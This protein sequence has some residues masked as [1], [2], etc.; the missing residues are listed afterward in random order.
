[1]KT[2]IIIHVLP[3]EI[4]RF[5]HQMFELHKNSKYLEKNDEV[6]IDATLNVNDLLVDWS[7]SKI[8][9]QY[10]ID[11]FDKLKIINDKWATLYFDISSNNECL[12]VDDKRRTAIRKYSSSCDNFIYLDNDMFYPNTA[13]KY[14]IESAKIVEKE[15]DYY[16]ISPQSTMLWDASWDVLINQSYNHLKHEDLYCTDQFEV[17]TKDYGDI[18][19][20]PIDTFKMGGGWFNMLSSKLL[21]YTDIPDSFGPYGLDDTFVVDACKIMK[22]FKMSVQQYVVKNLV[23]TQSY[24]FELHH[25]YLDHISFN[26]KQKQ[27]FAANAAKSYQQE[28]SKFI[29]KCKSHS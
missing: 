29:E 28:I 7:K 27:I 23:V 10:F 5:E 8:D 14:I 21:A 4:D 20:V 19:V 26:I 25:V 1:M 17:F 22:N 18:E 15:K 16:I 11:R 6:V 24:M 9:K 12:G 3:F 13:L 2:H